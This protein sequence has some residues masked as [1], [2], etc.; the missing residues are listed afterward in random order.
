[1]KNLKNILIVILILVL[2][3]PCALILIPESRAWLGKA[4]QSL[5]YVEVI[6][7]YLSFLASIGIAVLIYRFEKK[8]ANQERVERIQLTKLM[9]FNELEKA[10]QLYVLRSDQYVNNSLA[11]LKDVFREHAIDLQKGLT[12]NQYSHL[13]I[14]VDSIDSFIVS[15]EEDGRSEASNTILLIFRDWLKVFFKSE[16]YE[17]FGKAKDYRELLDQ[18]T[19]DLLN[20]LSGS[21]EK[22]RSDL[23]EIHDSNDRVIFSYVSDKQISVLENGTLL[24]DGWYSWDKTLDELKV[25]GYQKN[26]EFAGNFE[27][28]VR[29]GRGKV[30][31]LDGRILAKGIWKDGEMVSGKEYDWV[32]KK[33]EGQEEETFFQFYEDS[34]RWDSRRDDFSEMLKECK[35]FD[36]CYLADGVIRG[37]DKDFENLR[38][39]GEFVKTIPKDEDFYSYLIE[40]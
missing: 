20:A 13:N 22:Y 40:D 32:I 14:L 23:R 17:L 28:G 31:N 10:I 7:A 27:N 25:N 12:A 34:F 4:L 15:V 33:I 19:F 35:S 38:P 21:N 37:E 8:N 29:S 36:E 16:Y 11:H 30:Y 2:L 3:S 5:E 9:M 24:F 6:I 1:M 26:L 18:N 39:F